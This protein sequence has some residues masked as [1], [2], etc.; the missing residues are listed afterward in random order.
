MKPYPLALLN[1]FT[2]PCSIVVPPSFDFD[3]SSCMQ[4]AFLRAGIWLL[5][6]FRTPAPDEEERIRKAR[7]S[8]CGFRTAH[9][10]TNLHLLE[11]CLTAPHLVVQKGMLPV[12]VKVR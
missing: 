2:I 6:I 1:H 7:S 11:L 5:S 9:H 8:G 4:V 10:N 3:D 12:S